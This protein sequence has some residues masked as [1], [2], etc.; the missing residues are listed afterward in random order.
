MVCTTDHEKP[1]YFPALRAFLAEDCPRLL[2]L[3]SAAFARDV[4]T[5]ERRLSCEG[6]SFLTKTLP[7]MALEIDRALQGTQPLVCTAF[8][9]ISRRDARPAFLQ[10]LLKRVFLPTGWVMDSPCYQSIRL[11]RQ[12]TLW[13]KKL[14]KG[15]SDESLQQATE[16]FINTDVA[17]PDSTCFKPSRVLVMARAVMRYVLKGFRGLGDTLPRHGPGAVAGGEGVVGKRASRHCYTQ[18]ESV[19]RP[20]PFFFSLNEV[21]RAPWKLYDRIKCEFGLSRTEF[22]EKDAKGPRTIG[23]EPAE[24]QWCQQALKVLLYDFLEKISPAKGFINFTDQTVNQRLTALWADWDTL[25]MSKA[26]DRN[27]LVLVEYLFQGTALLTW[28]LACRTPGTILPDGRVLMY[29]KFA[30]MGSAL[31]FPVQ[32]MVYYALA[33]ASLHRQG[34]PWKIALH[35]VYVYGDDLVVPHGYF[36]GIEED[37]AS[38]GLKFNADKCCTHGKFRESCGVDAYDGFNVTPVRLRKAY[39]R[40][41]VLLQIPIVQHQRNLMLAGYRAAGRAFRQAAEE[42]A[43]RNNISQWKNLPTCPRADLPILTWYDESCPDE[44]KYYRKSGGLTRVR[45]WVFEPKKVR[46]NLADEERYLRESLSLGGPVGELMDVRNAVLVNRVPK[47]VRYRS[48]TERYRGELK[49]KKLVVVLG[50]TTAEAVPTV[51]MRDALFPLLCRNA[52]RVEPDHEVF[53]WDRMARYGFSLFAGTYTS[54]VHRPMAAS[55]ASAF[56]RGQMDQP[57]QCS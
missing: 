38:V 53:Q 50:S 54:I 18:L 56:S 15:Y 22:V 27:A 40:R 35:S 3:T 48:Y 39:P 46:M 55:T 21:S 26:S 12:I 57:K 4:E 6:E 47:A 42:Y 29:K 43:T 44:V 37:F 33:C 10:A 2:E 34:I 14:E 25:D 20:V 9:K 1:W 23:L 45:G 16:D 52:K 24:Y 5:L 41:G 19:F 17:L 13:C 8:K 31:C 28:M 30:P 36:R 51:E 11:L 32:A 49:R 7:T